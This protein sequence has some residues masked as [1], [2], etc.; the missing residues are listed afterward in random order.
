M[1]KIIIFLIILFFGSVSYADFDYCKGLC[2]T[3]CKVKVINEKF[4]TNTEQEINDFCKRKTVVDI[5][6]SNSRVIII[7]K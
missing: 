6:V 2:Y 1:K 7:Y 3:N 4:R 5:K